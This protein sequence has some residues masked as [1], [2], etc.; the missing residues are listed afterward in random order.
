L[1]QRA[2]R[3]T[4]YLPRRRAYA[5]LKAEAHDAG[6]GSHRTLLQVSVG[7]VQC[8]QEGFAHMSLPHMAA[9]YVVQPTIV[10]LPYKRIDGAGCDADVRVLL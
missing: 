2:K 7:T 6:S 4:R 5:A 1:H 10:A 9:L 3:V 8:I